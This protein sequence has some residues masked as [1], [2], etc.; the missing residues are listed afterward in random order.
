MII[1][2]GSEKIE[3]SRHPVFSFYSTSR[4]GRVFS[5]PA[6]KKRKGVK[7]GGCYQRESY[8]VEISLFT[9][10]PRHTPPY[11]KCRVTQDGASKIVSVH[12]FMLQCWQGIK[13]RSVVVRHLDG[14]SLNNTLDNLKYGTVKENVE[15]AF[16]HTGNYAEGAKNGRAKLSESDVLA[17]R[18]RYALGEM[19]SQIRK[20]YPHL[21]INSISNAARKITWAHI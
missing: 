12:R 10:Q 3:V 17:I 6:I 5:L 1:K 21:A 15:D 20:D 18:Q 9:V 16:R 11:R 14:N 19:A 7:R 2:V 13:P 8:W 4:D